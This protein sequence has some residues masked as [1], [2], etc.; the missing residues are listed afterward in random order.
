MIDVMI[1]KDENMNIPLCV[2]L[3]GTLIA[4]DTLLDSCLIAIKQKPYLIFVFPFWILSG[5]LS[6]KQ[7]VHQIAE[8]DYDTLLYRDEIL[9]F[10]E[11]A[12]QEGRE[13]VLATASAKHIADRIADDLG[14]FDLVLGSGDGVNLRSEYKRAE[15]VRRY[16]EKGYDYIG[17]S[18]AD[19]AVFKSARNA[20]LV[21][22]S[23]KVLEQASSLG[24]LAKVFGEKSA[25]LPLFI[26][27]IRVYQWVK[28]LLI[29]FP[30]LLAHILPLGEYAVKTIIAFFSFSFIAS[31]VYVINDLMDLS[32]DRV[33]SRKKERPFASGKLS[34]KI[35]FMMIPFL[36]VLG[37]VPSVLF[38]PTD[39]NIVLFS[40]F[41]LT[42]LYSFYL[43]KVYILDIIVLSSLYTIRLL[44]GA[45]A[46]DVPA[47]PWLL[48]FSMFI[49]ISLACVKRFTELYELTQLN[50]HKT[51]GRGYKIDDI[52]L[53]KMIGVSTG[54]LSILVF[55]LYVNSIEVVQLYHQPA[56]LYAVSLLLMYWI[57]RIWFKAVRGEMHDDPIVFSLRD[58]SGLF[59]F[60]LII[61]IVFGATI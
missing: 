26:K 3:D 17:D 31:T 56:Y 2:D 51:A 61:L 11:E 7:K 46:V 13:V 12:K 44:A 37:I 52:G 36:L 14:I 58:K 34:P 20:Y 49:F 24:N 16:G 54:L 40:Y 4:G 48:A 28:N 30:L 22:P 38:L 25:F 9:E 5:K 19:I 45:V 29:F 15:L 43:K 6:F 39:F 53:I 32:S 1:E 33:H 55:V 35:G 10:I 57:L 59:I 23:K 47:S 18:S 41:I 60:A 8:P 50:K 27:Q 42:T 21:E